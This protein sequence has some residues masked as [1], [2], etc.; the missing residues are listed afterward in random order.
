MSRCQNSER[1]GSSKIQIPNPLQMTRTLR[2]MPI[3]S[4]NQ[5]N[6]P[7]GNTR[8]KRSKEDVKPQEEPRSQSKECKNL[9]SNILHPSHRIPSKR[10]FLHHTVDGLLN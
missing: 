1:L 6:Q 3:P 4:R 2:I 10:Q 7:K 9:V 5:E 8:S